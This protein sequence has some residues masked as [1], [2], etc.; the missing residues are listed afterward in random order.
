MAKMRLSPLLLF[1][2]IFVCALIPLTNCEEQQTPEEK[3]LVV[4]VA[5]K[6]TDGFKRFLGSAKHFNYTVK[7]LGRGQKWMSGDYMS[8]PG[9]G[10]KVRLLK[11]ALEEMKN[12]DKVILFIDSYDVVFAS[13]PK[14]LL[15]K[16]QQARHKVVFSSESLIWPNRHLEDKYPHV[17]V[18]N[19]FLGS[20][21]FI[22]YLPNIRE[23]V[24]DWTGEDNDSDQLF[25]TKIYI[26]PV[27]RKSINITLDSKCRLFQNLHG[28]LDEV[29][30]KFEDGRVRARNV[31][32]DTLPVVIHG[33]GPT[34]LQI[35]YLGNYIPNT[36]TFET[37]CT[38]CHKDIHPLTAVKE[39]EYP[40]V[41]I[42]VFIQ[43]PTPFVTVFF[44]RLLK[45]QYPK[46]RLKLFIYNQEAHHERHV[47]S[48]LQQHGSL[49]QDVKV[50][51]PEEEMDEAASRNAG[52][53][54]CRTDKDCDYFFLLD[55]QVVLKNEN[56]LKIL[57][58][59]NLP[60]VAPMITRVGRLWSNFWGAL[61]A[62]GYYARSEDYVD[63]VQ[64]RRVGVWN[65]PYVSSVF[66]VK[67][68]LLRSE[69]ADYDLFNSNTLDPDMAVCHNIRNKGI[70]MYVTNMHT[71]GRILSTDNYQTSHLHNDLWQIFENPVDWQ[72]RYIHENY[73][74]IMKDKLIEN[75][76]PD[77][78]W[79]PIFSD[80]ACD[81][82]VEEMEHFGK[83]SGGGNTDTRIQGG[84]ENVPTIDIHM[85]QINFEKEWHKFL[86]EYIAPITEKMY[87][88]Y[89]TKC[90]SPLN[91]VV[92]YKPD[93][94]PL[95]APHHDAS[96][97]TINIALNSKDVDYQGG[98][99]RF[100]RY[101]CSIQAPRKGWTLMHPGRLTHYHE[102]LP[103]TAGV[104]Y[105]AVSFVDP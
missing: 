15:K 73:T 102:G 61:S 84:Y 33:N 91:F 60:I 25:F 22:G 80:V 99:C 28:A 20:G 14:E 78:Y 49:Y 3:L 87:P 71:F 41:V 44:E 31:L 67:A 4:T 38:V 92:R 58:E 18:G 46:N 89:Y 101:D 64:G 79:F 76:C 1:P 39:S 90:A 19:R 69:L 54:M 62:E 29:V 97:F 26:D 40:L 2:G 68:S 59:Q 70:F 5:T 16:F 43:Q 8:G 93:E 103:T 63:I 48:F 37:G 105:I 52:F 45:L 21:G 96:T 94:Q 100:L 13:G 57:I 6:E 34:K 74:Y 17:V 85:N 72:E 66:L 36:W 24:S 27:K 56:T 98:G 32:Y 47:S 88:G 81:H 30:L 23:M 95:L 50:V 55:V 10:Q 35:N 12:E 82:I 9:G 83:W 42:G 104:R 75:P 86:L 51:G 77:V 11:E 7:V 65:V 53:D